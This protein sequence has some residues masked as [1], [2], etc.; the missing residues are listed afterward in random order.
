MTGAR[1]G[2]QVVDPASHLHSRAGLQVVKTGRGQGEHLH[3]DAL[4]VHQ[5][6]TTIAEI[7]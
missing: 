7:G 4:L 3:V 5:R 6:Q 2:D 1:V